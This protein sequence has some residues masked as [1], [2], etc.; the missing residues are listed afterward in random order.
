MIPKKYK[1][2]PWSEFFLKVGDLGQFSYHKKVKV[3][4]IGKM[5]MNVDLF[6]NKTSSPIWAEFRVTKIIHEHFVEGVVIKYLPAR[7]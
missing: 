4:D 2:V 7:K 5:V 1:N 6:E 3:G